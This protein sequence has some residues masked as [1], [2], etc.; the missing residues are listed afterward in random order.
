MNS[1]PTGQTQLSVILDSIEERAR[2][3]R[4]VQQT[5]S[6]LDK[7]I[8][9]LVKALRFASN[10]FALIEAEQ[11]K[12]VSNVATWANEEI[13]AILTNSSTAPSVPEEP[14]E[15]EP[16]AC[17]GPRSVQ[18]QTE[19]KCDCCGEP[20]MRRSETFLYCDKHAPKGSA[21]I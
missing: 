9:A 7:D 15:G 10:Q 17:I 13:S 19:L 3:V 5:W 1:N 11:I 4:A 20:A 16:G 18:G 2:K 8:P 21:T 6:V 14:T 12:G